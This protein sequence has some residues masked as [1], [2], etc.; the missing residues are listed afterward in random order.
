MTK[1]NLSFTH[2]FKILRP[3]QWVKNILV[4]TPMLLSHNF[5]IYNFILSIKAFIIF[6]ITAS[7]IYIVNDII[8]VK[9]DKNHPFKKYRPYAAGLI[10]TNQCNVLILIL[11]ILCT[12]LL[13]STNKEFFFLIFFYFV[14]SNLYTFFFK[15][16]IIIDLLILSALYTSRILG[17]GF[18]TDIYVSY[19]LLS[20]SIF[21]FISLASVKRLIELVNL[22]RFK[23][24]F[25]HGRGYSIQDRKVIYRIAS[26]TSWISILILIF[27]INSPQ[28]TQLYTIPNILW[29]VCA[30][31]FFWI[32]RIIYV[33]NKGEIKD[34]P[35]VFAITD[36]ISYLCVLII[37]FIFWLGN[38]I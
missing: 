17:G 27:Y 34:D 24:K 25:L 5:D 12:L 1:Q 14:I 29:I 10:T 4:F 21:F 7:S 30:V 16:I 26:Y 8:D 15:K 22:N 28:V 31:M 18:I 3:H 37:L 6:S 23:K 9:S 33:S 13:I 32:T 20:F 19:W 2:F 38:T 35:I 36:K 11:L